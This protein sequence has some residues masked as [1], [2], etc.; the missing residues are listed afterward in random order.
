MATLILTLAHDRV[1]TKEFLASRGAILGRISSVS[2]VPAKRCH[3]GREK[4]GLGPGCGGAESPP[5]PAGM[6]EPR[7]SLGGPPHSS[8]VP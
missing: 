8:R 4:C 5:P 2:R 3:D 6:A 7:S 1:Q